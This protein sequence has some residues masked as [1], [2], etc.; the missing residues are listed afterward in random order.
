FATLF[1]S[2]FGISS[3]K[4]TNL[5]E[6]HQFIEAVGQGLF[7]AYHVMSIIV[8]MNMLIAMM[9]SSFQQIEDHADQEWKFARSKLWMSYF[10]PGST[11]P[12]PFNLIISPK[13]VMYF[14]CG[15]R[16]I[17]LYLYSRGRNRR[18]SKKGSLVMEKGALQGFGR[19]SISRQNCKYAEIMQRLVSRFIH[20]KKKQLRE[21][22]VNADDLLEIKQDISSLRYE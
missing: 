15:I 18:S 21:D 2:L 12:A 16:D 19:P 17:F 4:S 22:G 7:M 1:W 6:D 9:S 10:D 11:L 14:F 13:S 20:Q 3:P 8:L 5:S